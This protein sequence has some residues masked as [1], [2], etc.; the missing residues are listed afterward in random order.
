MLDRTPNITLCY[1]QKHIFPIEIAKYEN[2]IHL[3][4][5]HPRKKGKTS[6]SFIISIIKEAKKN[7]QIH[8]VS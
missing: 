6:V 2:V 3:K 5:Y 7:I 4:Q 8:A 1:Q